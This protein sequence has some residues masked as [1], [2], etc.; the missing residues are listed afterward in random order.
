MGVTSPGSFT[1]IPAPKLISGQDPDL[2][3]A[4]CG[5]PGKDPGVAGFT[6]YG[7]PSPCIQISALES[8]VATMR[9]GK[10][11]S[12]C[13]GMA[14][15]FIGRFV[16]FRPG[17]HPHE[18]P[19]HRYRATGTVPDVIANLFILRVGF[20]FIFRYMADGGED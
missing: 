7:S 13:S 5:S 4:R 16:N 20:I 11:F 12:R 10:F 2:P 1:G 17:M 3:A 8:P 6:G 18:A 14:F 15:L 19:G 9:P